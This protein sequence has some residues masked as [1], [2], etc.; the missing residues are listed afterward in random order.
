[1]TLTSLGRV[2]VA[3]PGTPVALTAD[4]KIRVSKVFFQSVPGLTGKGYI[5]LLGL[6]KTTLSGVARTLAPTGATAIADQYEVASE[7]GND[8][9][10]LNQL[11]IDMDV[12]GEGLLISYWTE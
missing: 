3:T 10:S 12:A 7:D 2:N 11:A 9:I 8:S 1:M 5:G 4:P 6:N